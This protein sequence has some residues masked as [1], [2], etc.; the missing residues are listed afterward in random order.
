MASSTLRTAGRPEHASGTDTLRS[1]LLGTLVAGLDP[2]HRLGIVDIG[3]A[4]SATIAFFQQFRCRLYIED[5]VA[6]LTQRDTAQADEEDDAQRFA[7]RRQT[8][9]R[10]P[11]NGQIDA[12]LCWDL[13]D[14]LSRPRLAALALH[15]A[16]WLRPGGYLHA[17]IAAR[18]EI[19]D[20]PGRFAVLDET[21]ISYTPTPGPPRAAP[22]YH[23]IDLGRLMPQFAIERSVLLRNGLQEYL[24]R[25]R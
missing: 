23:Q 12:V 1:V 10:A 14:Y 21:T 8:A 20:R 17:F 13:F 16:P 2:S 22:R 5:A 18:P 6:A 7:A 9:L 24:L 3:P 11:P 15:I 19:P 25:R 4:R